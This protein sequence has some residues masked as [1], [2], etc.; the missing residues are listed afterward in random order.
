MQIGLL[1]IRLRIYDSNS[2][3]SKR[4]VLKSLKDRLRNKFNVSVI[5]TDNHDKWQL[6]GIAV[7]TASTDK[8]HCDSTLSTVVN[9]IKGFSQAEITEYHTEII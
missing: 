1:T 4:K 9:F 8:A 6:A 2:L 5:E 3:K 7:V